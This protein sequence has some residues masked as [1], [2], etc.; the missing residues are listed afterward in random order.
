MRERGAVSCK[1]TCL[2]KS[3]IVGALFGETLLFAEF[4]SDSRGG[5][6]HLLDGLQQVFSAYSEMPR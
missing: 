3:Q 6:T 5:I 2:R 1:R 4:F